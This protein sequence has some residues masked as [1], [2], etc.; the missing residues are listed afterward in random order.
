MSEKEKTNKKWTSTEHY[1]NN[2][3]AIFNQPS[4]I[5]EFQQSVLSELNVNDQKKAE[6]LAFK[7]MAALQELT[8]LSQDIGLYD[9][10][11]AK[12]LS[13]EELRILA[14]VKE[15]LEKDWNDDPVWES[16][17][18]RQPL[19]DRKMTGE[20][21]SE[22]M[23]ELESNINSQK[24]LIENDHKLDHEDRLS[25]ILDDTNKEKANENNR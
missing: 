7:K 9:D 3:D 25:S 4:S 23:N 10:E 18:D 8:D 6:E 11:K 22:F 2:W 16:L 14:T 19:E 20:E 5:G 24:S 15:V 17:D 21:F 1:R 13:V 12:T